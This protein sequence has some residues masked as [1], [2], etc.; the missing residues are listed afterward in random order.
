MVILLQDAKVWSGGPIEDWEEANCKK[1][2]D[3][4]SHCNLSYHYSPATRQ[5]LA[6]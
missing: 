5:Q 4:C 2:C 1:S 3:G 6:Q